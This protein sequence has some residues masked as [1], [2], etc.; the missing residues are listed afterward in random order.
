MRKPGFHKFSYSTATV[1]PAT[2]PGPVPSSPSRE[3][4]T[5]R[6][7]DQCRIQVLIR[8]P[9]LLLGPFVG[10]QGTQPSPAQSFFQLLF[11]CLRFSTGG[12][13]PLTCIYQG[14]L[15]RARPCEG[16]PGQGPPPR[17]SWSKQVCCRCCRPGGG[18]YRNWRFRP[19]G[20]HAPPLPAIT[21]KGVK[22]KH[23]FWGALGGAQLGLPLPQESPHF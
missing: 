8:I 22:E 5:K 13:L 7:Y 21:Q 3:P 10:L 17:G 16:C 1:P 23:R 12:R 4:P 20:D 9:V 19:P 6:E 2:E 15:Q 14:I 11:L 18:V